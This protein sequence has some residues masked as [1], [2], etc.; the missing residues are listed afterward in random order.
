MY[1]DSP[2]LRTVELSNLSPATTYYYRVSG[3]CKVFEFTTPPFNF[4]DSVNIVDMYPFSVGLVGD[5]G[6]TEVS[7][8]S[9][10]ALITMAPDVILMTGDLSYAGL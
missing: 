3:S 8:K 9:V 5:L 10:D 4:A 7:V 1:Y 6:Q 2:V